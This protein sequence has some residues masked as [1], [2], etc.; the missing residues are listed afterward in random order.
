MA[1]QD[2]TIESIELEDTTEEE[3]ERWNDKAAHL[4]GHLIAMSGPDGPDVIE[5]IGVLSVTIVRFVLSAA[6]PGAEIESLEMLM[7]L[8]KGRLEIH[9]ANTPTSRPN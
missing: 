4:I 6:M 5:A 8:A 3:M 7:A 1:D 9:L 2:E